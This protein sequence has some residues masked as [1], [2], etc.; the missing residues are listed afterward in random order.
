MESSFCIDFG[1]CLR[2]DPILICNAYDQYLH[3]YTFGN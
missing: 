2:Y 1:D 3:F